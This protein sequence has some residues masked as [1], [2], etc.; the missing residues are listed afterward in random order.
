[1]KILEKWLAWRTDWIVFLYKTRKNPCPKL[2][3]LEVFLLTPSRPMGISES[4]RHTYPGPSTQTHAISFYCR[5]SSSAICLNEPCT[6][7]LARAGPHQVHQDW[8]LSVVLFGLVCSV[9]RQAP[10]SSPGWPETHWDLP[11]SDSR[12][13]KLNGTKGVYHPTNLTG[14][15]GTENM[16]VEAGKHRW[17]QSPSQEGTEPPREGKSPSLWADSRGQ[18]SWIHA[19]AQDSDEL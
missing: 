17:V 15:L 7:S 9:F 5:H 8:I 6:H 4:C 11:T 14:G 12:W 2:Y 19:Q 10:R 16:E 3:M 18:F 13:I 1:M